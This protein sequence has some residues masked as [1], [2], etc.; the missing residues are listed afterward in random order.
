MLND[1]KIKNKILRRVLLFGSFKLIVFSAIIGRLYKLQVVDSEKYKT[2]SDKN[3]ISVKF[4]E[5]SRGKIIDSQGN[6]IADNKNV[7]SLTY[8]YLNLNNIDFILKSL[9]N[10]ININDEEISL[11]YE[12]INNL[13]KNQ[14]SILLKE[15]LSW[16]ELSIIYV[17]IDDLPGVSVNS[18][19]IREYSKGS[20]YAHTVGYTSYF[21]D[22]NKNA[23]YKINMPL[24]L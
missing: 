9:K 14:N 21:G 23:D 11:I 8:S 22:K 5:P 4:H 19:S 10:L 24:L 3:R 16:K 17:N 6:I 12:R 20:Y 15:Y 13:N 7:Y 1:K 18:D 2:L